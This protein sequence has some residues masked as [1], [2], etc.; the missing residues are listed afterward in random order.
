MRR[1]GTAQM[2]SKSPELGRKE[3]TVDSCECAFIWDSDETR[4]VGAAAGSAA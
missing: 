1:G 3:L 2:G 4:G